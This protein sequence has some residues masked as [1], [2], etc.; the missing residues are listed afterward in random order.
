MIKHAILEA[1][2]RSIG[3]GHYT[4]SQSTNIIQW[5]S[6]V[7]GKWSTYDNLKGWHVY[8]ELNGTTLECWANTDLTMQT[9]ISTRIKRYDISDPQTDL[10]KIGPEIISQIRR[11]VKTRR[12]HAQLG[13]RRGDIP[14]L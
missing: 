9:G 12:N 4:Q 5:T 7:G 2:A 10:N 3:F 13:S 8:F 1:V 14:S 11:L 6:A